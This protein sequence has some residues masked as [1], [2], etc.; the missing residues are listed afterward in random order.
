MSG[1][2]SYDP[3][4]EAV[5]SGEDPE[6]V[7]EIYSPGDMVRNLVKNYLDLKRYHGP[8]SDFKKENFTEYY[9]SRDKRVLLR[10]SDKGRPAVRTEELTVE[11][12]SLESFLSKINKGMMRDIR[13]G[14]LDNLDISEMA[15]NKTQE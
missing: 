4:Y 8:C 2:G 7:P 10:L 11:F 12:D 13:N 3:W 6:I 5:Y 1:E 9:I 15:L 14:E